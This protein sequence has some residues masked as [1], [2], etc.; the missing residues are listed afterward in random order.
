LET[1]A[2]WLPSGDQDGKESADGS[3]VSLIG[4]LPSAFITHMS[5][6]PKRFDTKAILEPSGD[7]SGSESS[8]ESLVRLVWLEPSA[9]IT[10]ISPLPSLSDLKAMRPCKEDLGVGVGVAVGVA[11]GITVG[12]GVNTAVGTAVGGTPVEGAQ[13]ATRRR[14]WSMVTCIALDVG[15]TP[16]GISPVHPSNPASHLTSIVTIVPPS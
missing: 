13:S 14:S 5:N 3:L 10:Y 15:N 4:L 1:K 9:S 7:Q 16:E 6:E 8:W 11:V 2:M 12:A